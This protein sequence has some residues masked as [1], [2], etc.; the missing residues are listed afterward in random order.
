MYRLCGWVFSGLVLSLVLLTTSCLPDDDP[1]ID[2][3]GTVEDK[4]A[5]VT[6]LN[7]YQ[8]EVIFKEIK[9]VLQYGMPR[10]KHIESYNDSIRVVFTTFYG[11]L[12]RV[13]LDSTKSL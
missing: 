5:L 4:P 1:G 9:Y 8:Y 13:S 6:N 11:R 10:I 3:G 7:G 2:R 12:V